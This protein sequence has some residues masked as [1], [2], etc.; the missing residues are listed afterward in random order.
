[1][2]LLR[3]RND[4]AIPGNARAIL[5]NITI[6]A[7]TFTGNV[8]VTPNGLGQLDPSTINFTPGV[9]VANSFTCGFNPNGVER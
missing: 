6:T 3:G 7:A 9:D 2:T 5:G 8:Q 4:A 1:M